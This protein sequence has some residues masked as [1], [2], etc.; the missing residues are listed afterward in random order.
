MK[1]FAWAQAGVPNKALGWVPLGCV[2]NRISS[3]C[4][5]PCS[6]QNDQLFIIVSLDVCLLFTHYLNI[7]G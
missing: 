4:A 7:M 5:F 6:S 2:E 1:A 3:F